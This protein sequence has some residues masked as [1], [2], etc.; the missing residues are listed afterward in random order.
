MKII[1]I[2]EEHY[3]AVSAIYAEGIATGKATFET[4]VPSWETWDKSHLKTCRIAVSVED[5]IIGWAALSPVSSRCVYSGVAELSIYVAANARGQGVG[6]LLLNKLILESEA[7]GLWTL[8]AG[9]FRN[10]KASVALHEKCG[11]R[12]I[13]YRERIGK[14]GDQW[15]DN[16]L[17]ERRSKVV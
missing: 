6:K 10:N 4:K 13:G 7:N 5:Q 16:V 3:P 14:L 2:Y 17:M 1:P 8:Q 11:F 15:M 12:M 9:I